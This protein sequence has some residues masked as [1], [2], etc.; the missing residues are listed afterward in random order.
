MSDPLR[1]VLLSGSFEGLTEDTTTILRDYLAA[2][3][4]VSQQ[5][6]QWPSPSQE[7]NLQPADEAEVLLV[8]AAGVAAS[9]AELDR[10]RSYCA[11][12]GAVVAIRCAGGAFAGWPGFE[13]EVL[14]GQVSVWGAD[15]ASYQVDFGQERTAHCLLEGMEPFEAFGAPPRQ[16][17]LD[18]NV[19]IV[20][21]SPSSTGRVPLAWARQQ[22]GGRVFATT[23]GHPRDFWEYDFLRLVENA[24]LWTGR[25]DE[26][27]SA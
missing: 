3:L 4:V 6:V 16:V 12:G 13:R 10:I 20:A 18:G 23:L 2:R 5:V 9:A 11:A 19:E 25:V 7:V 21:E 27:G 8:F 22:G 14:G 24:V 1:L 17:L 15:P 26:P